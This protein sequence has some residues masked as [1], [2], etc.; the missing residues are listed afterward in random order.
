MPILLVL[1][2]SLSFSQG[3]SPKETDAKNLPRQYELTFRLGESRWREGNFKEA[4]RLLNAARELARETGDTEKG[5]KCLM[6]LGKLCWSL[7]RLEDSQGFY[8]EALQAAQD[9]NL[10]RE[11]VESGL[12]LDI[13]KLYSQGQAELFAGRHEKS[14]AAFDS[15]LELAGRIGSREHEVKC[16]RQL[17]LVYWVG[18]DLENFFSLN[19]RSLK[20]AQELNDP[21]E[22]VKSLA[23]M[24]FY[25]LK[26]GDY[27][28]ALNCYSDALDTSRQAESKEDESFCLKNIGLILSQLGFYERS[29]DYLLEAHEI[30]RQS[31]RIAFFPQSMINLGEGFRNRGLVSSDREDLYRALDYLTDALDS[32]KRKGDK[33]TELRALN[34]IGNIHLNLEKYHSAERYFR[35]AQELAEEAQDGEARLEVLNNRG[36]CSFE[37]GRVEKAQ[38]H[39]QAAL[40]LGSQVGKDKTLWETLFH[41]GQCYEKKGWDKPWTAIRSLSTRSSI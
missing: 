13:W 26:L 31:G 21:K 33:Q 27:S 29:L 19:K 3:Q 8:S 22:I 41:L 15:A 4:W 25:Y 1:F 6:L 30:N 12:A 7:G 9:A 11:A 20:L 34:N 28:R 5:V 37:T 17:G 40:E 18:E 2:L 16:L 36:V 35:L 39:F 10:K 38:R 23:N 24:G 14:V 32:A